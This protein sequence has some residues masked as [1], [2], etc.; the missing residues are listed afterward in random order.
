MYFHVMFIHGPPRCKSGIL[1]S[2]HTVWPIHYIIIIFVYVYCNIISYPED[3]SIWFDYSI[4]SYVSPAPSWS[5]HENYIHQI[6]RIWTVLLHHDVICVCVWVTC[7]LSQ[8]L[9]LGVTSLSSAYQQMDKNIRNKILLRIVWFSI[10][11][12]VQKQNNKLCIFGLD[13]LILNIPG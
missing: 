4:L 9:F 11:Q 7:V 13:G 1:S 12:N 6:I 2:P 10:K 5:E 8:L 3:G